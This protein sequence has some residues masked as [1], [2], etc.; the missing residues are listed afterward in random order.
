MP[1]RTDTPKFTSVAEYAEKMNLRD[2]QLAEVLKVDRSQAT[3]LRNGKRYRSLTEPLRIARTIG[4][5][6]ENLAAPEAA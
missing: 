3:K 5:P 4:M 1:R 6:V 2:W